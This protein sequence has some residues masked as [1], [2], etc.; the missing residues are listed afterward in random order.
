MATG[1]SGFAALKRR[2]TST[3][4]SSRNCV[5]LLLSF[6]HRLH[7]AARLSLAHCFNAIRYVPFFE[8]PFATQRDRDGFA[9]ILRTFPFNNFGSA[10]GWH[11][12]CIAGGSAG[13]RLADYNA[14]NEVSEIDAEAP[15]AGRTAGADW[16]RHFPRSAGR[17]H[18]EAHGVRLFHRRRNERRA[19]RHPSGVNA[20]AG[21]DQRGD[22][23]A[24][25]N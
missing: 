4:T 7:P 23:R 25:N 5:G 1:D 2:L 6:A 14:F 3:G 24:V 9:R 20:A 13:T 21:R 12:R 10:I 15:S 17:A 11:P 18:A 16:D 22:R 19:D 8:C